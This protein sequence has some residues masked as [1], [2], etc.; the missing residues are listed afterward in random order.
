[1]S[2]LPVDPW[3]GTL[4]LK[5]LG[6]AL[7]INIAMAAIWEN[8]EMKS[9]ESRDVLRCAR[10]F[11]SDTLGR[12]WGREVRETFGQLKALVKKSAPLYPGS[13]GNEDDASICRLWMR[14]F[15][16]RIA[17]RAGDGA[18]Y[19]LS[20][21]RTARL[22]A[23]KSSGGREE[24]PP[25]ILTLSIHEQAGGAQNK[26]VTVP[27]YLPLKTEWVVQ[28]FSD[29][30]RTVVECRWDEGKKRVIVEELV[31][32]R[33]VICDKKEIAD[34]SVYNN[35]AA[36]VLAARCLAGDWNWRAAEPKAEQFL[37]RMRLAASAYPDMKI[38]LMKDDDWELLFHDI[39][40]G[41]RT[42]QEVKSTSLLH[43]LEAYAGPRLVGFIERKAPDS[44][45]LL[46]G[47]KGRI[48]YFENAPPELSARLGDLIG[49]PSRFTVADG[50]IPGVFDILAPNYRTVQKTADLG[51]FWKT[52]Y[53][54][55][56][57]ELRRRYP[58]H[59]WP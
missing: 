16:H 33:N 51:S 45:V 24:P 48:T 42:L 25:L 50:R 9:G 54:Q 3:I 40:L 8:A 41:K 28:E 18:I 37:H 7:D 39:S 26:K 43:A 52:A 46:S 1:L 56:K 55:I 17:G 47:R 11:L 6:A 21:G 57:A 2:R 49:Y 10:D 35:E 29:V 22:V 36:A 30:V 59:P 14:V 23:K 5:S 27:L 44:I 20:D 34:R 38:P 12:E 58:K 4:L 32:F 31:R 13:S 15:S 53:P 19:G